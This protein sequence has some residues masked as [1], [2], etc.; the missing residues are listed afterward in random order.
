MIYLLRVR[1]FLKPRG[2]NFA[3]AVAALAFGAAIVMCSVEIAIAQKVDAAVENTDAETAVAAP[4]Q[5]QE[6]VAQAWK[7]AGFE[8]PAGWKPVTDAAAVEAWGN[9][10]S[11][12]A[13]EGDTAALLKSIDFTIS[14]RKAV[15]GSDNE[16]IKRTFVAGGTDG[17]ANLLKIYCDPEASFVFRR[18]ESTEF[19]PCALIRLIT[20]QGAFNFQSWRLLESEQGETI[21]VD[22]YSYLGAEA[23]SE[24]AERMFILAVPHEDRSFLQRLFAKNDWKQSDGD[25]LINLF[26][27]FQRG[28][29]EAMVACYKSMSAE[30]KDEKFALIVASM[31]ALQVD[32]ELYVRLLEKFRKK[33]PAEVAADMASIDV[34]FL[35]K[36][37]DQ[38][39]E[40]IDRIEKV[41]GEDAHLQL[42]RAG[43]YITSKEPEKTIKALRKAIEIEP[44]YESPYWTLLQT[45][46]TE[47]KYELATETLKAL[48]INFG[49]GEFDFDADETYTQYVGSPEFKEFQAFLEKALDGEN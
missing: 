13:R 49:Y 26:E 22:F 44:F 38:M 43:G 8:L 21:G 11:T 42:I 19:G 41:V 23:L 10:V 1:S 36:E 40:T 30:M 29:N 33:F 2:I 5:S 48:V 24:T 39:H 3:L 14:Y 7:A 45:A 20:P 32:E 31:A 12:A 46:V 15:S 17:T 18:I 9:A 34:Y 4:A 25:Q 28:D 6:E 47:K 37:F 27:A 35:K 16:A